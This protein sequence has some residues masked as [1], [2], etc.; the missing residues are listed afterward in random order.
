[1]WVN[2]D[3]T[4]G[5]SV[6]DRIAARAL[7]CKKVADAMDVWLA[8]LVV[9]DPAYEYSEI[10]ESATGVGLTEAPRGA[11]GHWIE[12]SDSKISRYQVITPTAWN[13]SPRD[14]YGNRG[15]IEDAL[16]G[17]PVK[18]I[19]QPIEMLRVVHSFDPCIACAV[20]LITPEGQILGKYRVS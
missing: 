4:R 11:L 19:D 1:M 15:P 13:A 18:E 9:G 6:L 8:E 10:P 3:Y 14:D 7:E 5:I 20:H 16:I 2:G 17:T 12:I